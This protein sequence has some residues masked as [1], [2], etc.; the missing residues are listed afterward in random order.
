[1]RGTWHREALEE[2]AQLYERIASATL[3]N[4]KIYECEKRLDTTIPRAELM[5]LSHQT[6]NVR[7]KTSLEIT[8][9]EK[10]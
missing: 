8:E 1:M 10:G 7:G 6:S 2:M 3:L 5:P 4:E 9:M